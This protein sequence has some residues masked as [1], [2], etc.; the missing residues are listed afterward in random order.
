MFV[1]DDVE[2]EKEVRQGETQK[3]PDPRAEQGNISR[4][5]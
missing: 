1:R 4:N 3:S 5:S 2:F